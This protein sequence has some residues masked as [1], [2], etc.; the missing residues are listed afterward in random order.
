MTA[1]VTYA[2]QLAAIQQGRACTV[3]MAQSGVLGFPGVSYEYTE[4]PLL[5]RP[6][7]HVVGL[8]L[9]SWL[10]VIL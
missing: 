4:V 7:T 9:P 2:W 8:T 10:I 1:W 6:T 5:V 3:S